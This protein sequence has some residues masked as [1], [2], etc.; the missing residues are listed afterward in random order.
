[1]SVR[2]SNFPSTEA[3][4]FPLSPLSQL[5]HSF[6]SLSFPSLPFFP[7]PSSLLSPLPSPL[8]SPFSFS[9]RLIAVSQSPL[10]GGASDIGHK[11]AFEPFM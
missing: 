2:I 6:S 7:S 8:S 5:S 4:P 1:M 11:A 10:R 9:E 3:I